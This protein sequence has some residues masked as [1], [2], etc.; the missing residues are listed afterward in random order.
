MPQLQQL[1][2]SPWLAR[3][4]LLWFALTLCA[5]VASPLVN[6]QSEL[7]ICTG[8]GMLKVVL[9]DDGTVT[10]AA[11]PDTGAVVFCPLCM[12]GGAPSPVIA[13]RFAPPPGSGHVQQ[14][15]PAAHFV[16]LTA[17]PMPARGPPAL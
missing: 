5:A 6:P 3:L 8:L 14:S 1:R 16:A 17:A 12:V 2:N 11:M 7:V 15:I 10:A 4:A 9:A 13:N